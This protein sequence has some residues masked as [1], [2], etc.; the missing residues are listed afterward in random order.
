MKIVFVSNYFNHHQKPFSDAIYSRIGDDYTFVETMPMSVERQKLGWGQDCLPKYVVP[1]TIYH[2]VPEKIKTLIDTANIVIFGAAPLK[3]IEDRIKKNKIVFL[4]SERPLKKSKERWKI[5]VR[6]FTW[7]KA[8][9]QSPNSYM[10]AASAYTSA[11]FALFGLYRRKCY[12]WGYFTEVKRYDDINQLIESKHPASILWGARFIEWKHP[13]ISIYV[14]KRLKAEGYKF[15][16]NMIGN[17]ELQEQ[18]AKQITENGL[19]DCVHLLGSMKPE[20]VREHME[21]S[22]I[23]LFTSDRNEGWGAVLNES[24]NSA[25]AVVASHAIGAVPF[26]VKD[27]KNGLIYKDGDFEDFYRKVKHLLDYP[28]ERM[29]ISKNAYYTM[30]NEWNAEKAACRFIE[31]SERILGGDKKPSLYSNGV[32]SRAEIMRDD[33]MK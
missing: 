17:G 23:F 19:E 33:W 7:R 3:L 14:A 18:I 22:E 10:L 16:L 1:Y 30:I 28:D 5:P 27:K 11:D 24:M 26:L 32:C 2:T 4:Y 20:Q 12:K 21:Q 31:L 9:P 25:C 8:Y 13:E 15:T 6:L 29:E